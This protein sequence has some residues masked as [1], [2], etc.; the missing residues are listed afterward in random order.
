MPGTASSSGLLARARPLSPS[1]RAIAS[2]ARSTADR[3][4]RARAPEE[5]DQLGGRQAGRAPQ[6]QPLPRSLGGRQ[7]ADRAAARDGQLERDR[8]IADAHRPLARGGRVMDDAA[9]AANRPPRGSAPPSPDDGSPPIPPAIRTRGHDG[10]YGATLTGRSPAAHPRITARPP[11][12]PGRRGQLGEDD[13]D[14]VVRRRAARSG[15]TAS[16][17]GRTASRARTRRARAPRRRRTPATPPREPVA[18]DEEHVGEDEDDRRPD[19][20]RARPDR[21]P[22]GGQGEAAEQELLGDRAR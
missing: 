2:V 8:A 12:P 11:A 4:A 13:Q 21:P 10:G 3:P 20:R 9:A 22:P 1:K 7:L 16:R 17:S 6:L 14:R 5:P 18:A 15:P 19:D